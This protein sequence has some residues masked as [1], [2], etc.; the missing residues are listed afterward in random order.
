MMLNL[1]KTAVYLRL[2]REDGDKEESNSIVNQRCMLRKVIDEHKDM[3][4]A[5]VYCD[6]GYTG[7]NF[8]RPD[9]KRM[10]T[11]IE[12]GLI[13]CVIVKD[14]SR[15]GRDYIDAGH[16]IEKYFV[17]K[18]IRFIAVND[19]ID[20]LRNEYDMLLPIK[21]VINQQYAL[22]ISSKVQS[23][24]KIKQ[25]EGQF[26]G[27][28]A[29]YGYLRDSHDKHKLSPDDYAAHIVRRIYSMYADGIGKIR[30]ANLLNEEG[31]LCPSE[32]KKSCGLQYKNSNRME[33]T[34]YWT[35]S[36]IDKTL[37]NQM[38]IGDMIQ[39]KTKRRMKGK[40]VYLPK[41][42][43]VVVKGTHPAIVDPMLWDR[44]QK[45][46]KREAR[47]LTFDQNV[48]I[49]A[50][51][52][53]CGDCGRALTKNN[54]RGQLHYVCATYKNYGK[55]HCSSHRI[56]QSVLEEIILK[57]LNAIIS[58]INHLEELAEGS[59]RI[60][61][62]LES[63]NDTL[64]EYD[65]KMSRLSNHK[66]AAY[67]DYREG[68]ITLEEYLAYREDCDKKRRLLA[69]KRDALA[70]RTKNGNENTKW[71]QRLLMNRKIEELD[72]EIMD[73]MIDTIYVFQDKTVKIIYN[74]CHEISM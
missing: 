47:H 55:G 15:F 36:T 63:I 72:K 66:N 38:Y 29:C 48:S 26:I 49:F 33:R 10:I 17:E 32:Y 54:C 69:M 6:D 23:S 39:G 62:S 59:Q 30:I 21:N 24:F 8:D 9:F 31:I 19:H 14:L 41:E 18:G 57:D 37:K 53:K 46:L 60:R 4:F 5:D 34:N 50:G 68:L 44:V 7:T 11:D 1:Y 35:Y 65:D 16:Y 2:S 52:L 73:E 61:I 27:A 13:N 40:A 51:F 71:V 22:D 74:F 12:K 56:N 70:Q 28:F 43:W 20:S 45:Q 64:Q 58:S 67:A 42:D 25:R 3:V